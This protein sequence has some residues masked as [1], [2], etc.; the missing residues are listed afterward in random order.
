MDTAP[1]VS[2]DQFAAAGHFDQET[3]KV[4]AYWKSH[5]TTVTGS[6]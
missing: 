3:Q 2:S 5:L 1:Q 6:K 4:D